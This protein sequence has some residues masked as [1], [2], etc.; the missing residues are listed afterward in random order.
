MTYLL[1]CSAISWSNVNN[2]KQKPTWYDICGP[3]LCLRISASLCRTHTVSPH[4]SLN[5]WAMIPGNRDITYPAMIPP[6]PHTAVL[7]SGFGRSASKHCT[8][9]SLLLLLFD[10]ELWPLWMKPASV[11]KNGWRICDGIVFGRPG[12][13]GA[14]GELGSAL[15]LE[16]RKTVRIWAALSWTK[17]SWVSRA[18]LNE[19][20]EPKGWC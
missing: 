16:L 14:L 17:S 7:A 11:C 4:G 13:F 9:T 18:L 15:A 12:T 6:I 2:Q 10:P 19:E 5:L 20:Y 3:G 1:I 8:A